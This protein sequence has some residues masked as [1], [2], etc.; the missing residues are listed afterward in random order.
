MRRWENSST[1][2]DRSHAWRWACQ[3]P[4]GLEAERRVGGAIRT[5]GRHPQDRA[6]LV[7]REPVGLTLLLG[8]ERTDTRGER[9]ERLGHALHV[10]RALAVRADRPDRPLARTTTRKPFER[11]WSSREGRGSRGVGVHRSFREEPDLPVLPRPSVD[12]SCYLRRSAALL[13]RPS[14]IGAQPSLRLVLAL[15]PAKPRLGPSSGSG[16]QTSRPYAY[17]RHARKGLC[18]GSCKSLTV[19]VIALISST[20]WLAGQ[21]E[22]EY[23]EPDPDRGGEP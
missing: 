17:G 19:R 14:R 1:K 18:T 23:G 7:S 2:A 12:A 20:K 6:W 5:G 13:A 10:E 22:R 8:P 11:L 21:L 9:N 4:L 16:A 3:S 15:P